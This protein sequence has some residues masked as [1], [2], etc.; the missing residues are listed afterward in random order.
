MLKKSSSQEPQ[1]QFQPNMAGNML[2]RWEFRLIQL[3]GL[4]L[5]GPNKGQNKEIRNAL[6]FNMI[7]QWD[8]EILV[9]SNKVPRIMYVP[10]PG[11]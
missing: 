3:K 10:T 1:C 8:K 5:L 4:A 11:A 7:D 6:I 9:C 2:G